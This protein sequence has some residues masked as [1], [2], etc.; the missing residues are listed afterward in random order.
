MLGHRELSLDDYLAILKRR[1]WLIVLCA[2]GLLVVGV[3]ISYWIPP[4]YVSQTMVLIEQQ[5]VPT[6]YVS[7]VVT[8][9]LGARVNAMKEQ[10]LSRSRLEP[11]IQRFNLF[12]DKQNTMED[13]VALTQK[14]INVTPM[15]ASPPSRLMPGFF[16]TFTAN[17]P[18]TAQRV[19]GEITSIFVSE[20]LNAREQ[21]AEGTTDFLKQ[22]LAAAKKTLDEQDE[23]LAE[24][25]RKYIGR[26]PSQESS[27]QSTLQA[28]TT[29]LDAS[30]QSLDRMQQNET[31][32][33]ALITQEQHDLQNTQSAA[34]PSI[35][36]QEKQLAS[37]L[38]QKRQ[39]ESLYTESHPDVVAISRQIDELQKQIAKKSTA[40]TQKPQTSVVTHPESPQLQQH[41]AQLRALQEA[42][43]AAKKDQ[44]NIQDQIRAYQA[45]IDTSP[46]VTEEYNQV[47]RDH[48]TALQ[49]YNS[50]LK[51]M[52]DSS[53]ATALE[54]R[55]QGEQFRVMDAPNL[56]SSPKYP[57]RLI[58]AGGGFIGGLVLGFLI[59]VFLEYR[60]D[61]IRSEEDL[62]IFNQIRVLASIGHLVGMPEVQLENGPRRW[63]FLRRRELSE[64]TGT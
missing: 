40:G 58:G 61:T 35:D 45:R 46:L 55:Q 18:R 25:E 30:T 56:P 51:K 43:G 17:D 47:T 63:G 28:L 10:V 42:M 48:D 50:L 26:L 44:S 32:L 27:N 36:E 21:S 9:D 29:Q 16:V 54:Q 7:P 4:Q 34:G 39:L 23:K 49:F 37:L 1:S 53:M 14:A 41:K 3:A 15:P 62:V 5:T 59:A 52:D 6:N 8:E 2:I 38:D 31:L 33:Q 57:V 24:F 64:S 20:N 60:D 12:P 11:I 19:C 22:Q 13:R